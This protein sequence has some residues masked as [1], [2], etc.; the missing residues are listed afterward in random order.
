VIGPVT[1]AKPGRFLLALPMLVYPALH[2]V[3]PDFVAGIVPPWIPWHLFWTY[4]TAVTI[5]A[6]GVAIVFRK[7]AQLAATLLGIEIFLFCA[8]IHVFLVFPRA[9]DS[10]AAGA[11]FGDVPSRWINF[12]KDLGLSGAAFI[13]AGTQS[14]S[15]RK[16]GRNLLLTLGRLIL[17]L[18]TAWFGVLHFVYPAYAPGLPPM[19]VKISFP[20][21]GHAFWVYLTAV[22]LLVLATCL[23]TNWKTREA[24]LVLGLTIMAFD[25]VTWVPVFFANP[26]TLTGNWLKDIGVAGGALILAAGADK[27]LSHQVL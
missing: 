9:G 21:P 2:F 19:S 1:N 24:A 14:E 16:T 13:F 3:Y 6:A 8:L 18:C 4:F 23:A 12:P 27:G 5:M 25:L 26:S 17:A 7:H 15:F 22:L 11:M 10:W 20:I